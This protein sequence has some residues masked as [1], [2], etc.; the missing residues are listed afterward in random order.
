MAGVD[1]D[2]PRRVAAELSALVNQI[3]QLVNHVVLASVVLE[4]GPVSELEET[5]TRLD[6][7]LAGPPAT[8]TRSA[9]VLVPATAVV[10]RPRRCARPFMAFGHTEIS[11]PTAVRVVALSIVVALIVLALIN[12]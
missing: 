8:A 12:W 1:F 3:D 11:L 6:Q 9:P 10:V 7:L 2:D 4:A 5:L